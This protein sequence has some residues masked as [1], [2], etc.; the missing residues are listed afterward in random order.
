MEGG[1]AGRERA[2]AVAGVSKVCVLCG[3]DCSRVPR[4]KNRHGNYAC[5]SCLAEVKRR[6]AEHFVA[7]SGGAEEAEEDAEGAGLEAEAELLDLSADWSALEGGRCPGC[8]VPMLASAVVCTGCG[9]DRRSGGSVLERA[10]APVAE[11]VPEGTVPLESKIEFDRTKAPGYR[12]SLSGVSAWAAGAGGVVVVAGFGALAFLA[13]PGVVMAAALVL[14]GLAVLGVVAMTVDAFLAG[15][16]VWGVA[17]VLCF[18]P[19]LNLLAIPMF[20]LYWCVFGSDRTG[21]KIG[22]WTL[23]V[24]SWVLWFGAAL[25]SPGAGIGV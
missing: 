4:V 8:G 18:V 11:D 3:E 22:F 20:F 9:Y 5:E 6:K 17:G 19:V 25:R 21:W 7:Y 13:S 16:A 1:V 15:R 23:M 10:V 14:G 2:S 12:R 24:S